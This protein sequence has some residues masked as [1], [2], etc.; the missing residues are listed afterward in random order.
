MGGVGASA[1]GYGR[2]LPP[3][4]EEDMFANEAENAAVEEWPVSSNND[5]AVPEAK[6]TTDGAKQQLDGRTHFKM[7]LKRPRESANRAAIE[8]TR[9]LEIVEDTDDDVDERAELKHC[10]ASTHE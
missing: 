1:G 3:R 5:A 8:S 6:A 10:N 7:S 9:P 2:Q 4:R